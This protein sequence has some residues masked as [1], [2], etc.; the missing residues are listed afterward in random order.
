MCCKYNKSA[1]NLVILPTKDN[2]VYENCLLKDQ[3]INHL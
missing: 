2:V 3:I 1:A